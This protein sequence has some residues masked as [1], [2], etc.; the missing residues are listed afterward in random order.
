[1]GDFGRGM[2]PAEGI[3]AIYL[4]W[5][6]STLLIFH[7]GVADWSTLAQVNFL[8]AGGLVL[9][10]RF[11]RVD[12]PWLALARRLLPLVFIPIL[13]SE[14]K[15][16]NDM[17]FPQTYFDDVVI[18]W[19]KILFS[20]K[21]LPLVLYRWW[22]WRWL[23]EY[24]HLAYLAYYLVIPTPFVALALTRQWK[25]LEQY[26]TALM[27]VFVVCQLLFIAFPVAGP[28]HHYPELDP[29]S[30]GRIFPPIVHRILHGGSSIGTAFPSSHCAVAATCWIVVLLWEKRAAWFLGFIVP[31]LTLGTIYGGFH[32]GVDALA[33]WLLAVVMLPLSF[34]LHRRWER[35]RW[36]G[37]DEPV[38]TPPPS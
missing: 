5:T 31:A 22:P 34:A 24:I 6:V 18:V 26:L 9:A 35:R 29:Y 7:E 32:Y 21:V 25:R 36:W 33:G 1:M 16:L 8:L 2:R 30:M 17:F 13:Y 19:E 15:Y 20:G 14:V 38:E 37:A 4:L 11:P 3:V 10:G 12:Q 27:L 23:S 28:F